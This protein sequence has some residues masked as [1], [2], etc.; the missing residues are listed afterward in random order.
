M[1]YSYF[2]NTI[3]RWA[4]F[5]LATFFTLISC[6]VDMF[7]HCA[8]IQF[9]EAAVKDNVDYAKKSEWHA[10]YDNSE[11]YK[12]TQDSRGFYALQIKLSSAQEVCQVYFMHQKDC[13]GAQT[14]EALTVDAVNDGHVYS[15]EYPLGGSALIECVFDD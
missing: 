15:D 1:I 9:Q 8:L 6:C 2:I 13:A 7:A 4:A 3:M 14:F 5:Q 11:C 12:T 10:L